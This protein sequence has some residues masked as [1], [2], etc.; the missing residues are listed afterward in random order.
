MQ[1]DASAFFDTCK[2]KASPQLQEELHHALSQPVSFEEFNSTLQ[3]K[4]GGK[5]PGP[6]GV[7]INHLKLLSPTTL[8]LL[9]NTLAYFYENHHVPVQWKHR[10][11]A[12]I[13]KTDASSSFSQF[14]PIM[15]LDEVRKLWLTI[16]KRR[17]DPI[18]HKHNIFNRSQCGGI[19]S[20][21]PK[22]QSSQPLIA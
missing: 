7:T 13:P 3:G 12:L 16:L 18:L 22:T 5:S 15:L 1:S 20:R 10:T 14:R 6:S 21:V 8:I 2:I 19:P 9:H 17:R 4:R 11:M